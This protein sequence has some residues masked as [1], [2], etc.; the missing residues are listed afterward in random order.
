MCHSAVV[1]YTHI[2]LASNLAE[3]RRKLA[4]ADEEDA[5][6]GIVPHE[7]SASV[8]I[9][10]ALELEEQA[11]VL[12]P[13]FC[14]YIHPPYCRRQLSLTAKSTKTNTQKAS[15]QEKR[16]A[17][18]SQVKRWRQLQLVYMPGAS[19]SS[20]PTY[21]NDTDENDEIP[22]DAPLILP[23]DLEPAQRSAI[24][25]HQVAEH[26]EQFRLA[27]LEDSL[28]ELRR[29]RRIRRTLLMN[30]RFQIAGQG[31]RANTRSRAVIDGVQGQI[32][33]FAHRYRA[34]YQAILKLNPSGSWCET[35]LELKE[36]DN[37]GPGKEIE[38]EGVGDG[39][40]APSWIWLSNPRARNPSGATGHEES[41]TENA[42]EEEVND[43]IRVEWATSFA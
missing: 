14:S 40:Y 39:S 3:V 1:P 21:D 11:Y 32:N 29:A 36:C 31:R 38:E 28:I 41:A 15:A 25:R 37:R 22:Q 9:R 4:E 19:T 17:F 34:A 12:S 18:A 10:T 23:S 2:Q 26:E 5:R 43:A 20:L 30:H 7:V 35:Y 16:N 33:K 24:C 27:Q 42:T 13:T 8:F 6:H